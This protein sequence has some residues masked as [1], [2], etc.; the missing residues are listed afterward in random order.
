MK[1]VDPH[2]LH[3]NALRSFS[4]SLE[5]MILFQLGWRSQ[6]GTLKTYRARYHLKQN[7]S[8][9]KNNRFRNALGANFLAS[10]TDKRIYVFGPCSFASRSFGLMSSLLKFWI[11]FSRM[12]NIHFI[13]LTISAKKLLRPN[14]GIPPEPAVWTFFNPDVAIVSKRGLW[15][16]EVLTPSE[17]CCRL[18]NNA[19]GENGKTE[20]AHDGGFW[21][22][23]KALRWTWAFWNPFDKGKRSPKIIRDNPFII[24]WIIVRSVE[25]ELCKNISRQWCAQE[26]QR[27]VIT[28][29]SRF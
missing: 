16:K 11:S 22:E 13:S 26:I 9:I 29:M 27:C 15:N 21:R 2:F 12:E 25:I 6:T 23:R 28:L 7:A 4:W 3:V 20:E 10:T 5:V 24:L 17:L 1:M 14:M 8:Q 19:E 18:W